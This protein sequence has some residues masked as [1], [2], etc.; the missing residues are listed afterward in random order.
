MLHLAAPSPAAPGAS[1][2]P[3]VLLQSFLK[4]LPPLA[5]IPFSPSLKRR[6]EGSALGF[7]FCA[8]APAR[9]GFCLGSWVSCVWLLPSAGTALSQV[10]CGLHVTT[11]NGHFGPY[12]SGPLAIFDT[13]D[14]FLLLATLLSLGF[15]HSATKS[16]NQCYL[17]IYCVLDS[18]AYHNT[19]SLLSGSF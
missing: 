2:L 16:H 17:S 19:M 6:L 1:P 15:F 10:T 12:L 4:P 7:C 3:V 11:P 9:A 18:G 14:N 13:V 5:L 8:E